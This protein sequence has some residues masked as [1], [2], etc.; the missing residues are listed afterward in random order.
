VTLT[1]MNFASCSFASI[2][3]REVWPGSSSPSHDASIRIVSGIPGGGSGGGLIG[4]SSTCFLT[5]LLTYSIVLESGLPPFCPGKRRD[6]VVV[7][8]PTMTCVM[9]VRTR[10]SRRDP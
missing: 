9:H 6:L 5:A 10:T 4:F 8:V 2:S 7:L 3:L 1:Y